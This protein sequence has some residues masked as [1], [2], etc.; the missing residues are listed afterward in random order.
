MQLFT[1]QQASQVN[2]WVK[3]SIM[4]FVGLVSAVGPFKK[5]GTP[6]IE[7][8]IREKTYY[9]DICGGYP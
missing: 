1:E 7:S 4:T 8:C 5:Y 6:V 9:L 3:R 2:T